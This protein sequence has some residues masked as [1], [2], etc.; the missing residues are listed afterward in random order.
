M[1][2]VLDFCCCWDRERVF[3]VGVRI[4]MMWFCLG[5]LFWG[6]GVDG[7][8]EGRGGGCGVEREED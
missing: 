4:V 5:C 7:E 8:W 6:R 1:V 2:F 3:F